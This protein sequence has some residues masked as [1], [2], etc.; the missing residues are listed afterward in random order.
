MHSTCWLIGCALCIAG[1]GVAAASAGETQDM[2]SSAHSAMDAG[3]GHDAGGISGSDLLGMAHDSDQ[4]NTGMETPASTSSASEHAGS[5]PTLPT[6]PH[7]PHVGW[8]SL[9]PGSIQ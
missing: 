6:R 2:G 1:F 4:R 8:Q 3:A 9:L 5:V 7:Q